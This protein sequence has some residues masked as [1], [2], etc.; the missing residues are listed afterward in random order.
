MTLMSWDE[1]HT[2]IEQILKE[3]E[4]VSETITVTCTRKTHAFFI[5]QRLPVWKL[6]FTFDE[7]MPPGKVM[8]IKRSAT[9]AYF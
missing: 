9:C 2:P 4:T 8:E 6:L 5:N 1:L 7:R 3:A